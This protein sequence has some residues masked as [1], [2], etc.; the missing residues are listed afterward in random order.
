MASHDKQDLQSM[1]REE[2]YEK[3]RAQDIPGKSGMSKEELIQA[4][5]G[6][7]SHDSGSHG[8]SSHDSD[9][10]RAQGHSASHTRN[11]AS[12]RSGQ[13]GGKG[14]MPSPRNAS[15]QDYKNIPGNQT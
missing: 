14:D 6:S 10:H 13:G 8:R 7:G 5:K 9:S 11:D 2:L 12:A 1:T 4:L 15:P 3:A